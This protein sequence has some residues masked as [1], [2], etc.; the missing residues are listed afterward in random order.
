MRLI[1]SLSLISKVQDG[2]FSRGIGKVYKKN[3]KDEGETVDLTGLDKVRECAGYCLS[4][5]SYVGVAVC[6]GD[7][8]QERTQSHRHKSELSFVLE[9]SVAIHEPNITNAAHSRVR[10]RN[11]TISD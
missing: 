4:V 10:L 8:F 3:R 6:A 9:R 7:S 1:S 2:T 5:A 11:Y